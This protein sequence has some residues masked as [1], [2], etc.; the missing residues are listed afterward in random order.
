MRPTKIY[1]NAISTIMEEVTIKG[2]AHIT[3]GGF[4]ENFP[5]V[6]PEGLGVELDKSTWEVPEILTFIEKEGDIPEDEMYG[7]FNMGVGMA[8]FVDEKD[9]ANVLAQLEKI[10]ETASVIGK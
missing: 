1:A 9:A 3:G 7:I 8:L 2:I 5:R 6:L 10:G 4:Y